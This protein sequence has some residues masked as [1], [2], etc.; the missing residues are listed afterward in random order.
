MNPKIVTGEGDTIILESDAVRIVIDPQAGGKIRSFFSKHS[1]SEFF[2]DFRIFLYAPCPIRFALC[3]R[4]IYPL[5]SKT[6]SCY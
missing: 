2:S 4:S 1:Q 6:I 3:L 5:T